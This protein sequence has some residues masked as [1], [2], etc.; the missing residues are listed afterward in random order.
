MLTATSLH[1]ARSFAG[2]LALSAVAAGCSGETTTGS[3]SA[4]L[5]G[6]SG[7]SGGSAP[8][9]L[10]LDWSI[11]GDRRPEQCDLSRAATL[12]V[13]IGAAS[14]QSQRV[15]QTTCFAFNATITLA[16]GDYIADAVLRDGAGTDLTVPVVLQ[17]FEIES[18]VPLRV[19]LEFPTSAFYAH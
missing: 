17:P 3:D 13:T 4:L 14:G 12:A 19:P 7:D 2:V 10:L 6:T 5:V 8:G 18:G 16:P 15:E 11:A 9:W 1:R